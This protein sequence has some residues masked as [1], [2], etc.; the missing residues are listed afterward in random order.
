MR[1]TKVQRNINKVLSGNGLLRPHI[2]RRGSKCWRLV[3]G[4]LNPV[5]NVYKKTVDS[6]ESKA[7]VVCVGQN[8]Y[9]K[10]TVETAAE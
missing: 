4:S 10:A 9:K 3:D 6:L 5:M 7:V 8:T 1:L 2:S